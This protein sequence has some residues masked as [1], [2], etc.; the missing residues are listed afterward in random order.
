MILQKKGLKSSSGD[1]E[2]GGNCRLAEWLMTSTIYDSDYGYT[3]MIAE[4]I[5]SGEPVENDIE[6]IKKHP[7]K[8]QT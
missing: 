2:N 4:K 1:T 5:E 8:R 7:E 3:T 6:G